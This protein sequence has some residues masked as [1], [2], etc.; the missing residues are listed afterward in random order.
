[1]A[2]T[3]DPG[4]RVKP[5]SFPARLAAHRSKTVQVAVTRTTD[6]PATSS[7]EAVVKTRKGG[8]ALRQTGVAVLAI[9]TP[10]VP[11]AQAGP[12]A[13]TPALGTAQLIEYQT[14]DVFFTLTN[15]SDRPQKIDHVQL[16]FPQQL[17]VQFLPSRG[18]AK[19]GKN[20]RL[21]IGARG[22][23]APGDSLVIHLTL[24]TAGAVQPGDSVILLA[25]HSIDKVDGS[26]STAVTSQKV[27]FSVLGESGVLQ[28]LGVPSL[29][30]VPG[31]VLAVVLWALWTHV[32]P[33]RPFALAPDAGL[34][35]KVVMW[36][37]ALL[38][39][40]ALPFLYPT[41]TSWFGPA[42]DYRKA[43]G[44]DDI[45]Y[46]WIIAAIAAFIIWFLGVLI[47]WGC[48]RLCIP[49]END[50]PRR[51]LAKFARRL[52]S[53]NLQRRSA[54]Y[55]DTERVIIVGSS[56]GKELVTPAIAYTNISLPPD[57][58]GKL[59]G[60]TSAQP[61]RLSCFLW[62]YRAKVAVA[63][64]PQDPLAEPTLVDKAQLADF[65]EDVLVRASSS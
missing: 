27:S 53:R 51:L 2:F 61:L 55:D 11:A 6:A 16:S 59:Q 35:G 22:S 7:V 23:L 19:D 10:A 63:Y 57:K 34:E 17:T 42:R 39:S 13:V 14:T 8:S 18:A 60:Y 54:M 50:D 1:M 49:Q 12:I 32:Y 44:L 20:G 40:L 15:R 9:T 31:I 28:V 30:F 56:I 45:L 48:L 38:P 65:S 33:R 36:V 41:I 4:I 64:E 47:R 5:I 46:V 43:Y 25:V 62:R 37:F 24:T 21:N 29:L 26:T 52:W 58:L 3:V